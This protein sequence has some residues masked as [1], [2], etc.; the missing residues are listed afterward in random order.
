MAIPVHASVWASLARPV[1]QSTHSCNLSDGPGL[2]GDCLATVR[3]YCKTTLVNV[4]TYQLAPC[5]PMFWF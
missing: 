1:I 3:N 4:H 5:D 2:S